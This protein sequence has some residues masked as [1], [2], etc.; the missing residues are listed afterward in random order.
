MGS[1]GDLCALDMG[2]GTSISL[3]TGD[4]S[5]MEGVQDRAH[6]AFSLH[7]LPERKLL[8]LTFGHGLLASI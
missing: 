5:L 6:W 2:C 4:L 1:S 3:S 8:L 7:I